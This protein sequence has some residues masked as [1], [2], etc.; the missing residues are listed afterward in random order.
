MVQSA[1]RHQSHCGTHQQ[2]SLILINRHFV[3]CGPSMRAMRF[4]DVGSLSLFIEF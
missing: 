3:N 2:P 1:S 4:A